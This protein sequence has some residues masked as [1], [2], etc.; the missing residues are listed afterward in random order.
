MRSIAAIGVVFCILGWLGMACQSA[1]ATPT[2]AGLPTTTLTPA[3][4]KTPVPTPGSLTDA[5]AIALIDEELTAHGI[6]PHTARITIAGEPRW[7]SIRY[8]SS[9]TLDS[10]AFEPQTVLVALAVARAVAR[11][12]PPINGGIRLAVIPGGESNVGLRVIVID[13]PG[14][15]AWANGSISDQ[16]FVDAW[17]GGTITK[18]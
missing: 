2:P 16:E 18:E 17:T 9:L 10:R 11:V 14:L 7:A 1:P 13:G 8:S 4:T 6:A 15:R 5:E 12:E 3:H